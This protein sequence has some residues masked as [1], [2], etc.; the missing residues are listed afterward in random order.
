MVIRQNS[1][2]QTGTHIAY[3]LGYCRV[4]LL[5]KLTSNAAANKCF[6]LYRVSATWTRVLRSVSTTDYFREFSYA[7]SLARERS[8]GRTDNPSVR[9][10]RRWSLTLT[11][12]QRH[13]TL[14]RKTFVAKLTQAVSVANWSWRHALVFWQAFT[15]LPFRHIFRKS[16]FFITLCLFFLS[17]MFLEIYWYLTVE[18]VMHPHSSC[19][20]RG[21]SYMQWWWGRWWRWCW[22]ASFG[23]Y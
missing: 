10:S 3:K 12:A 20:R 6:S 14:G 9:S 4:V 7:Q 18:S 13:R 2:Q 23:C 15:L 11:Q 21:I 8:V 16:A 17:L 22:W 5:I 1:F 19:S